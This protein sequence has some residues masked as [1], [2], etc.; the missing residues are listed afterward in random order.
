[1]KGDLCH[2]LGLIQVTTFLQWLLSS[3]ATF[4]SNYFEFLTVATIRMCWKAKMAGLLYIQSQGIVETADT[5]WRLLKHI[6][7]NKL[8]KIDLWSRLTGRNLIDYG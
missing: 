2:N 5:L 3:W 1:M 4:P 6:E 8:W 7:E